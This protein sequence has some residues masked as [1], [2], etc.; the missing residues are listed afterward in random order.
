M[1]IATKRLID[2]V[3]TLR[4]EHVEGGVKIHS[5]NRTDREGYEKERELPRCHL[6]EEEDR[7]VKQIEVQTF[8]NNEHQHCALDGEVYDVV[9]PGNIFS[10]KG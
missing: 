7:T 9:N 4:Y 3:W 5:Y 2:S 1:E 10:Y 8:D 6:V